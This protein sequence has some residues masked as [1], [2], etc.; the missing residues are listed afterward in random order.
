M[1]TLD[2][3]ATMDRYA[4]GGSAACPSVPNELRHR[5]LESASSSGKGI[6]SASLAS[7]SQQL[8][9]KAGESFSGLREQVVNK[10]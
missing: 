7:G 1:G 6:I 4:S 9:Q 2:Q 5:E 8:L 3:F 10:S